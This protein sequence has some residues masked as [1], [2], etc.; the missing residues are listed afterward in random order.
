VQVCWHDS[1]IHTVPEARGLHEPGSTLVS[2]LNQRFEIREISP[3]ALHL[4]SHAASSFFW[5]ARMLLS[6]SPTCSE[7]RIDRLDRL[8]SCDTLRFATAWARRGAW[9][10]R[11]QA[12]VRCCPSQHRQKHNTVR[13]RDGAW[14]RKFVDQGE[15]D[16][17][18]LA[19]HGRR[20]FRGC[21]LCHAARVAHCQPK[22][23]FVFRALATRC[24]HLK[25]YSK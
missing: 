7:I 1:T 12:A 6:G 19:R 20:V 22:T 17:S 21:T 10:R 14:K 5:M 11:I 23:R 3:F 13:M 9:T 18:G 2:A 16:M 8:Y 4:L 25:V 15:Q 24:I